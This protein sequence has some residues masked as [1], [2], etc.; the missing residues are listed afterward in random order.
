[1]P[2]KKAET[3]ASKAS[4][5]HINTAT[6][7]DIIGLNPRRRISPLHGILFAI[8]GLT[9]KFKGSQDEKGSKN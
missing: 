9:S 4:T 5:T 2:E 1:M 8:R 6:G 3:P 7:I